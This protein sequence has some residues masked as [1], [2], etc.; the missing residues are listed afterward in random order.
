MSPKVYGDVMVNRKSVNRKSLHS[1]VQNEDEDLKPGRPK[2]RSAE[3][4]YDKKIAETP[5]QS[6][7]KNGREITH[8]DHTARIHSDYSNETSGGRRP[9][10]RKGIQGADNPSA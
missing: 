7:S 9:G 10:K 8:E 5:Q 3:P 6:K 4:A 2:Y 1:P